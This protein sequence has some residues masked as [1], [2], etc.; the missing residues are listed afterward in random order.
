MVAEMVAILLFEISDFQIN[1]KKMTNKDEKSVFGS[2]F[3]NL[4]QYRRVEILHAYNIIDDTIKDA[5]DLVRTKRKRYLHLWSQDYAALPV[6]AVAV[7]NA[8]VTIVIRAIG[9]DFKDGKIILN[10]ALV[11]YLEKSGI[12][13]PEKEGE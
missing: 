13:E 10:P 6:D 8:T 4:G 3:E 7:Y 11:K 9:Q 5:F 1:Q 12:Y 2:S